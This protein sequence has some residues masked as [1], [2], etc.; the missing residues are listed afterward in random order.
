[1]KLSFE[2]TLYVK[3]YFIFHPSLSQLENLPHVLFND[4]SNY[5]NIVV[6]NGN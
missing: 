2:Q 4:H 6:Y 5:K 1:M 3:K